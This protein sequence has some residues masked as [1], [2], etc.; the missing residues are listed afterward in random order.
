IINK[1]DNMSNRAKQAIELLDKCKDAINGIDHVAGKALLSEFDSKFGG[2]ELVSDIIYY[3]LSLG[4]EL[5]FRLGEYKEGIA[6][7]DKYI[8]AIRANIKQTIKILVYKSKMEMMLN[9]R[10][11]SISSLSETLGLAELIGD[12]T[13]LGNIYMEISRMFS[14]RYSGLALYFIRKAETC[15]EKEGNEKLASLAKVDRALISYTAYLLNRHI[16]DYKNLKN[17]AERIVCEMDDTDYDS[18]EKRHARFVKAYV[19]RDTTD[20]KQQ[21]SEAERNGALPSICIVEEAYIAACIENGDNNAALV[22]FD[23]YARSA[24]R[25]HGSEI[26]NYLLE[27][28]KSLESNSRIAYIPW[29]IDKGPK[30]PTN[31]FDILDHL[32]LGEELWRYKQGSFLGLFHGIEHEGKF[33][34]M[35]MPDGKTSLVPCN[36]AFNDYYRGQSSYY[37]DCYPSLYRKGMTPAMQ[38]VERVKYEEFKLLISE[39]PITKIFSGGLYV[40]YPDGS[41]DSVSLNIDS[42]A[43]A[44]HYGIKTELIDVTVDK[45]VAAF[46]SSTTCKDDIYTPITTPQQEP[47]VFYHYAEIPLSGIS[48]KLRAVGLQP[49]SRPGE[50]AGFVV[51]MLPKENF[52]KIVRQVIPFQHDPEIAEF[53]FNYTN[54]SV[55]LFPKSILKEKADDIKSSDKFSRAAFDAACG[56]FYSDVDRSICLQYIKECK[57]SIVD[58]PIVS[59]TE[60]EKQECLKQWENKGFQDTQ[61]K[62]I[63]RFSYNGPT[64]FKNVPKDE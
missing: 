24:E 32:S 20:L 58:S 38:F 3:R 33:E 8:S 57:I 47:G 55:K 39:Y 61:R 54:R 23:K 11:I 18:F 6:E 56:E 37:E 44:Q 35:V 64:E 25:Q 52:N 48:S 50:Q 27:L 1:V 49:F 4:S 7:I 51:E 17:E 13:I 42:L 28:K 9:R 46:F 16:D 63:C 26:R 43:L 41:S 45:F 14:A 5:C 34:T 59:F 60:D 53:I 22:E 10:G 62:I 36:L 40:N 19:L 2:K 15:H 12:M 29:H 21:I 31:L 30:E